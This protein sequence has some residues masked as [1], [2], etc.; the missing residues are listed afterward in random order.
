MAMEAIAAEGQVG[1]IAQDHWDEMFA[2]PKAATWH[3]NPLVAAEIGRRLGTDTHWL[4]WVFQQKLRVRPRRLLSIG[5]GDG[6]HELILSR[7][8]LAEYVEAFD[9]SGVGI[10]KAQEAVAEENL[11]A[12]FYQSSFDEF[13]SRPHDVPFDAVM[14]VGSLH[15]VRDL[16]GMLSKVRRILTEDGVLIY[17]EY[18]GPCYIILPDEQVAIVNNVIAAIPPEYKHSPEVHWI[19]PT[20]EVVLDGDPSESV[21]SALIRPFLRMYFDVAWETGFGG[22]LL[23][24]LFQMLHGDKL[25]DDSPGSRAVVGLC[26]EIENALMR[27]G[28]LQDDFCIGVAHPRRASGD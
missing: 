20:I 16:E 3:S 17:N 1:D 21:R 14:F 11:N 23:H 18:V 28:L 5:C 26:I 6:S 8:G 7:N 15:H 9:L 12:Q 4:F 13:V 10:S 25:A 27:A 24:P 22:A 19:N 2:A